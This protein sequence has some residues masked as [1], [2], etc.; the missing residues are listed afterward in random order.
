MN[1]GWK[2]ETEKLT[3]LCLLAY[4]LENEYMPSPGDEWICGWSYNMKYVS[5]FC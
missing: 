5:G 4:S 1:C 2:D 3:Y